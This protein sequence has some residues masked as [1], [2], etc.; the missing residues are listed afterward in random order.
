MAAQVL[1]PEDLIRFKV[2]LLEEIKK[3]LLE[4]ES[5]L[6]KRWLKSPDIRKILGISNGTLQRMRSN[7]TLPYT[8]ISG[9]IYYDYDDVQR[10][11]E[12]K[13]KHPIYHL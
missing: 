11:L 3:L 10:M 12:I 1:T 9:A 4:G 2:E 6:S 5:P 13:K 7:G 8:K